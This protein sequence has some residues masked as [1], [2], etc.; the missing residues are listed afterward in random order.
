MQDLVLR[1]RE[2]AR[3]QREATVPTEDCFDTKLIDELADAL[4]RMQGR[5][6]RDS[7]R[8]DCEKDQM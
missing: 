6:R 2:L 7:E 4:E 1:A 3:R 5:V 8:W